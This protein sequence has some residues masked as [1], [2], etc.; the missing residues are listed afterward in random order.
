MKL[1]EINIKFVSKVW[2]L[3][4]LTVNL[5]L[6]DNREVILLVDNSNQEDRFHL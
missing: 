3:R 6:Q 5:E 1:C 4:L 2:E